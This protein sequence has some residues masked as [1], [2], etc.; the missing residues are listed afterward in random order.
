MLSIYCATSLNGMIA[1]P[2]G[3]FSWLFQ[4][5]DED[6]GYADFMKDV[7]GIVSGGETYRV[8]LSMADEWFYTGTPM[9]VITHTEKPDAKTPPEVE[10]VYEN[11]VEAVRAFMERVGGKVWILG[12]GQIHTLLWN[13]GLVDEV[14]V[15]VHP[16]WLKEGIP[17]L[18]PDVQEKWMKLEEVKSWKN[19]LVQLKYK[20][21]S[22]K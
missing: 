5:Q 1:R 12:G 6:Y 10:F 13:A 3:D 4:D 8:C 9:L 2:D 20:V 16:I 18:F 15:S 22:L 17:M 7:K 19:G 14:I 21:E 11:P